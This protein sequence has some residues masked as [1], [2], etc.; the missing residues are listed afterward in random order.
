MLISR[1]RAL[2]VGSRPSYLTRR[3]F[4]RVSVALRT[5][6]LSALPTGR[7]KPTF[8]LRRLDHS[9]PAIQGRPDRDSKPARSRIFT[10]PLE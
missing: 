2:W 9:M 6:C 7:S 3:S 10:V 1:G 5:S 4:G 8:R